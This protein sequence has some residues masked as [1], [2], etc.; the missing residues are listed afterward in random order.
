L[1]KPPVSDVF[2]HLDRKPFA[3]KTVYIVGAGPSGTPGVKRIPPDG[4]TIA[5][6]SAIL[7]KRVFTYWLVFDCA[8]RQYPWW[9][10]LIL[11]PSTRTV[12]GHT[13]VTEHHGTPQQ[14][15]G[16]IPIHFQFQFR[17][18]MSPQFQMELRTK[19]PST[20]L[21]HGV[22]RGGASIA[23]ASF[24]FAAWGGA[25]KIVLCG[26]DMMGNKHFDGFVNNR[27]G[28]GEWP[29]CKKLRWLVGGLKRFN[30]IETVSLTPTALNVEV[31]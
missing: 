16:H 8:I 23:G 20:P 25:S 13:L 18:T 17:P 7:H 6:N 19:S 21:I 2:T 14:L 30:K 22:L 15:S 24:Q 4:I 9:N 28:T 10:T 12:F 31:I 11:D 29:I 26:V 27:M 3:G 1:S 5:L